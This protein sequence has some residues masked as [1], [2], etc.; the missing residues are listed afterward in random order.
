M[1][2]DSPSAENFLVVTMT[3]MD[4][5]PW[6]FGENRIETKPWKIWNFYF[7]DILRQTAETENSHIYHFPKDSQ[8][9][10]FSF[11]DAFSLGIIIF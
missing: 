5:Q 10:L 6:H 9:A 3:K 7:Y 4:I 11:D 8:K 2:L 1:D